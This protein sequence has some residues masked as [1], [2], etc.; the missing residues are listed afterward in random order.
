MIYLRNSSR[1]IDPY[2]ILILN[3]NIL[4]NGH[5]IGPPSIGPDLKTAGRTFLC[6][7]TKVGNHLLPYQK[8]G[9]DQ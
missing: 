9:D 1:W 6:I 3:L 2:L 7:L 8:V 4:K 5:S